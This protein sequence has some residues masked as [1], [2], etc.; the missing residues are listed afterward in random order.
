MKKYRFLFLLLS[1]LLLTGCSGSSY[2]Y[3]CNGEEAYISLRVQNVNVDESGNIGQ[4]E[5]A[6]VVYFSSVEEM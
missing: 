5:E 3:V 1:I 4:S 2:R 6:P